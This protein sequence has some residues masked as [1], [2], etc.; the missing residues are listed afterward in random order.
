MRTLDYLET[1]PDIDS[2]RVGY[3]G[4]IWG[5]RRGPLIMAL[6]SRLKTGVLIVGGCL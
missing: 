6:E 2:D 3:Y 5:G 1:R 4:V